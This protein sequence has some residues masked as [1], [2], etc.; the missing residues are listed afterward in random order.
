MFNNLILAVAILAAG[1]ASPTEIAVGRFSEGDL[2]GWTDQPFKGKTSYTLDNGHLKAHS[3]NAGS[4]LIK[5]FSAD[6]KQLQKLTWSWKIDHSL[7]REDI[8]TKKGDDFAARIY[9]VFPRTFFWRMRAINY[10]WAH[11]LPKGGEAPSPYTSNSRIIAV[12]S[13]NE[14]AGSWVSEERNV[15]EDYRRIFGEEPPR[16]G[17]VAIMTDTDDTHDEATAWYGDITLSAP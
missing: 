11:K 5:K 2:S 7:Q 3:V 9:V 8:A 16:L 14:K 1:A 10:V 6:V 12:E 17:G 4:G 13:G 15:Y